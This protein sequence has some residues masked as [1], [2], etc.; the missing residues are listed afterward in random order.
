MPVNVNAFE[1]FM[2]FA[3][4]LAFRTEY[5]DIVS[6]L[7]KRSGFLPDASVKRDWKVLD[8]NQNFSFC[9]IQWGILECDLH[10]SQL[11]SLRA[12]LPG[13]ANKIHEALIVSKF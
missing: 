2:P 4:A 6:M 5:G 8:D 9:L 12:F 13:N 3:E 10:M 11:R 7:A 1:N